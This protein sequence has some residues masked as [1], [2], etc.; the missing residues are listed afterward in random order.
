M[1]CHAAVVGSLASLSTNLLDD[2]GALLLA[3]TLLPCAAL[4]TLKYG[5][6]VP[7]PTLLLPLPHGPARLAFTG[8][9]CPG[10]ALA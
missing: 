2:R 9:C 10:A 3:E 1:L 6:V 8:V 4:T 5:R 7:V